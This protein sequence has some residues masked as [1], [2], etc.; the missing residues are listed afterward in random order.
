MA[1]SPETYAILL[2]KIKAF[3]TG[4]GDVKA[5]PPNQLEFTNVNTNSKF[6]VTLPMNM[7]QDQL[8]WIIKMWDKVVINDTTNDL[9]YLGVP[10]N[11]IVFDSKVNF[12]NNEKKLYVDTD[13]N[14]VYR[15][16]G[17]TYIQV[18]G[19]NKEVIEVVDTLKANPTIDDLDSYCITRTNNKIYRC[20]YDV[21]TSKYIW[22]L[23][24]SDV[25][26][27]IELLDT[28]PL[29]STLTIDDVGRY[30]LSKDTDEIF[31]CIED[32]NNLGTYIWKNINPK[33]EV[34]EVIDDISTITP[35]VDTVGKVYFDKKDNNLYKGTE[36]LT[37]PSNPVYDFENV[38]SKGIQIVDDY[39]LLPVVTE[40]TIC[41][42]KADYVDTS[43]TPNV[44]YKSGF[45]LWDNTASVW[46]LISSETKERYPEWVSG[47]DYKVDDT[48]SH[49]GLYYQV[50]KD[51]TSSVTFEDDEDNFIHCYE[52]Y[53]ALTKAQ[54]QYLES[55]GKINPNSNELYTIVDADDVQ[56]RYSEEFTVASTDWNV[57]HSLGEQ[58]PSKVYV[59]DDNGE[60]I[61]L[62]TIEF[63][64]MNL[65]I[66]HF[67][68]PVSGKVIVIK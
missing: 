47:K 23:T 10:I 11:N 48:F 1:F 22:S 62:P 65:L 51:F 4:I 43:V 60:E 53:F 2:K 67:D 17:T 49:D 30:V 64:S 28:L 61:F 13:K 34:I 19:M 9:E 68:V 35:S 50:I 45:Y 39:S 46:T 5:I 24:A 37:D 54:F 27:S 59:F 12:D 42:C 26:P 36:D 44:E 18:G 29:E 33:K 66:V 32:P 55:V 63:Y 25:P 16:N 57:Q 40:D 58:Y 3:L 20:I 56:D 41:Y 15:Y 7:T 8:D 14:I 52:K 21:D 6:I 31:K 38:S